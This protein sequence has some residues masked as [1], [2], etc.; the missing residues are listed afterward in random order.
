MFVGLVRSSDWEP[1][2]PP[3]PSEPSR[4]R[5]WHVPWRAVALVA[6]WWALL[7]AVPV[8]NDA[9]GPLAGYGLLLVAVTLGLWRLDRWCARQYWGG[10][11]EYQS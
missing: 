8:A 2:P 4:G 6:T 11:R 7:L 10:L 9:L 5:G 1:P 3:E